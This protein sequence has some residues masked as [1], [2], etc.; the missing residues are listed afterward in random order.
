MRDWTGPFSLCSLV[1]EKTGTFSSFFLRS[2]LVGGLDL[3]GAV[4]FFRGTSLPLCGLSSHPG[5][6]IGD[7]LFFDGS[8]SMLLLIFE[9]KTIKNDHNAYICKK[10]IN[11]DVKI[12]RGGLQLFQ[13]L[14]LFQR[15]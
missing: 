11:R 13:R 1:L 10:V 2:F 12:K 3:F 6:L 7:G 4:S 14:H 15:I 8:P 9:E 5:Y